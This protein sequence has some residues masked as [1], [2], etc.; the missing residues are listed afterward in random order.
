MRTRIPALV[1]LICLLAGCA[2][3][4]ASE[5]GGQKQYQA[6][7]LDLFD[8]VTT[9]LG[10]GES[11]E[12][13]KETAEKIHDDLLYYHR[14]FD[15]Y[16]DY[17]GIVNLK[18]LNDSAGS[19]PVKVDPVLMDLLLDCRRYYDLTDGKV[20]VFFGSVLS[21][22]HDARVEAVNY[23]DSA[24]LPSPEA[25]EAAS[26]HADPASVVLD[27]QAG[28]VSILDPDL[29]LDVGAAAKG[30]SVQRAAEKAPEG[31][32]I[33]VGGNV[34]ATGPKP[35]GK[36]WVVGIQS[37]DGDGEY[38]HT[39]NLSRGSA[40]TSGDYQRY[41]ILDGTR[42]HHI[43]DPETLQPSR[44]WRSVTVVCE[45]SGLA[46][47]LSTALFLSDQQTGQAILDRAGAQALWIDANG[48]QYLSRGFA[49]HIRS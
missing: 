49:D 11:E 4:A 24:A 39:L 20:N 5:A 25:L 42:Y 14:L 19:G 10:Y 45:D 46:D 1:L 2:S 38:V 37:P 48:E 22:W 12:A 18:T 15:I 30:W 47:C 34:C 31:M 3:P 44:Y 43:I 16:N 33:S 29:R 41:F 8:T 36:N 40:V 27:E 9:I 17:E 32:L 7:F 21:L 23:P 26:A 6:S 35:S 28:T 13:F